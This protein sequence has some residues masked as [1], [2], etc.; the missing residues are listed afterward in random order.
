M[1]LMP[2]VM[3]SS[4]LLRE[5]ARFVSDW[6]VKKLI[7]LSRAELTFL[8]VAKRFCVMESW[9]AVSCKESRFWRTPAEREMPLIVRIL[10][11]FPFP[12]NG[13]MQYQGGVLRIG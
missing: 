1:V 5:F 2:L 7:A 12:M 9:A 6:A 10:P 11:G 13:S 4:K 8:P 3:P